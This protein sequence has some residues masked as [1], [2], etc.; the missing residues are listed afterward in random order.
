[1]PRHSF[2]FAGQ[3]CGVLVRTFAEARLHARRHRDSMLAEPLA[4]A[5]GGGERLVPLFMRG[6]AF[7]AELL[8]LVRKMRR[9]YAEQPH[10]VT[11]PVCPEEFTDRRQYLRVHRAG[12]LQSASAREGAEIRIA[13]LQ[14]QSA[15]VQL[16]FAQTAAHH[17]RQARQH[18]L[19]G[20]RVIGID[21]ARMLVT[22]RA[23][24]VVLA[25][26]A[27]EPGPGVQ[28][29][30]LAGERQAER[31]EVR[32]QPALLMPGKIANLLDALFEQALLHHLT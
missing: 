27:V 8:A 24:P 10:R 4:H 20:L 28:T 30:G 23:W 7:Q 6:S 17:L 9:T 5:V 22:D 11:I 25:N 2:L 14:L 31:T 15:G 29:T 13:Q 26:S 18:R 21:G 3:T 1:M 12:L 19:Q 16:L 32:L